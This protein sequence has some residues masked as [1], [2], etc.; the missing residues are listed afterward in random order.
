M[1]R[2][3]FLKLGNLGISLVADLIPNERADR[4]DVEIR[5]IST[6]TMLGEKEAE[7]M[8]R[9]L[10]WNPDFLVVV[11][12]NA[13]LPGPSKAR[14]LSDRP[15]LVIS[16]APAKKVKDKLEQ[17]GF[18]YIILTGDALLCARREFLDPVEMSIFNSDLLKV[19]SVCGAVKLVQ[20]ELDKLIEGAKKGKI[21]LPRIIGDA[22]EVVNR[23]GFTN[24]YA[25]A[26]ALAAYSMAEKVAELA[27]KSCFM[28]KEPERYILVGA[29][30]HEMMR[31]AAILADEA[32]EIEKSTDAVRR[33]P[34]ART[35]ETL[36][37]MRLMEK[38]G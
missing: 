34:H 11:S 13:S 20:D 26:K 32:R 29:A 18:G 37:K 22:E 36:N 4:E 17:D 2:I 19:L 8:H 23:A 3:G 30:A 12:P 25:K 5:T 14:E 15:C 24:P 21:E 33:N 10:E 7:E 6:S 31:M 35:G 27:T 28:L 9:L 1:V 38:P 16:D